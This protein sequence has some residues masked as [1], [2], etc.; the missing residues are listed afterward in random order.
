MQPNVE[1]VE[2]SK[3]GGRLRLAADDPAQAAALLARMIKDGLSV[4]EF[5]REQRNLE[6][7]FM[8]MVGRP[9][10]QPPPLPGQPETMD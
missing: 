7:A 10:M 8:A 5:H 4:M 9:E 2:A 6:D 1:L 3:Q